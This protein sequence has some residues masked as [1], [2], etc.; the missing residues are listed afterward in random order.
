MMR[1]IRRR[2]LRSFSVI[3]VTVLIVVIFVRST[4]LMIGVQTVLGS[5]RKFIQVNF[6]S[7]LKSRLSG[8][9]MTIQVGMSRVTVNGPRGRLPRTVVLQIVTVRSLKSSRGRPRRSLIRLRRQ[10]LIKVRRLMI[11]SLK[12]KSRRR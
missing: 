6:L 1:L 10:C 4:R 12:T 11:L 7:F 3:M 2:L 9:L 8:C 5:R